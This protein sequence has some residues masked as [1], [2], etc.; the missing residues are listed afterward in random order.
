M[1][2]DITA[3][4]AAIALDRLL[5]KELIWLTSSSYVWSLYKNLLYCFLTIANP[6]IYVACYIVLLNGD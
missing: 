4:D 3:S 2:K 5:S 1:N 6:K